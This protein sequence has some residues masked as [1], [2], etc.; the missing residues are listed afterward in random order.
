MKHQHDFILRL[1]ALAV[2]A[3]GL[4]I[5]Y[6][7]LLVGITDHDEV[8]IATPTLDIRLVAAFGLLYLSQSLARR[9]WA[10]W[11]I[12][13]GLYAFLLGL[14]L[15]QFL[16]GD[17]HHHM[18]ILLF[19][20]DIVVPLLVVGCLLLYRRQFTVRSDIRNF[21]VSLRL[22]C[23]VLVIAFAYGVTG[24]MLLDKRDFHQ[25]I[26]FWEAVHRTIDQF[27]ITTVHSLQPYTSRARLFIDSLSTVSIA[28]LVYSAIA[29]FQPI[30]ARYSDQT[31]NREIMQRLLETSPANSEDFFKLWPHDKQYL[32]TTGPSG[33]AGIAYHATRGVALSAGAPV[34]VGRLLG[35][36]I[37]EFEDMCWTNDWLPAFIHVT[38]EHEKLYQRH[39]YAMQKIGEEAVVDLVHFS[40]EVKGSKYF[41]QIRN[42]FDKQNFG[43]EILEP[44]HSDAL[45]SRLKNISDDWLTLPGRTERGFI[46]AYFSSAYL[47]RC[48]VAVVRDDAGTIQAFLNLIPSYDPDEANFDMLR[49]TTASPG[50]INDY[51]LLGL[52]D[53]LQP[54]YK[55]FNLGLS[56]LSGI[57]TEDN[58]N[59]M[60]STAMR[61]LYANGDRFYSF[62][63]LRRFKS[64]YEP[65]WISR[66]IA[67]K[68]GVRGFTR[69]YTALNKAMQ[70][71]GRLR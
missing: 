1:V 32:F 45:I 46:M 9:K 44:P 13:V 63:G 26:S 2:A 68:A 33:T 4:L 7:S 43:F 23:I 47:Q 5:I 53:H 62:S 64:K 60:I 38:D 18:H 29:L 49:H 69:T 20:R 19:L 58:G 52:F 6:T 65:V 54:L 15:N 71:R 14:N 56:P 50:N 16:L 39:G 11:L 57:D 36:V 27:N 34:G 67:H 42:K 48:K 25:E 10:A 24:F 41:R 3:N 59:N 37:N 30:K 28:A 17:R 35:R 12:A 31:H 21:A 70:V 66:Y 8:R 40:A 55:R 61:F 22:V 51:L